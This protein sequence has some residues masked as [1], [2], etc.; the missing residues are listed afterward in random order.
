MTPDVQIRRLAESQCGNITREQLRDCGFS[1]RQI[2]IRR[3]SGDLICVLPGI[4]RLGGVPESLDSLLVATSQ[5]MAYEGFFN[6]TTA[7]YLL[8]L[9]GIPKPDRISV[10]RQAGYEAPGWLK[11]CRLETSDNPSTR[12]VQGF[13][14]SSPERAL[15]EC[16][17]L[18]PTRQVGRALDDALRRRLTTLDRMW[19]FLETSWKGRRGARVLRELLRMRD[20]RDEKVRSCFETKMLAILRRIRK[21]RF[22]PD[23]G[24]EVDG[25]RYFVDFYLPAAGLGIECHSFRWHMGRHNSD[26]RRDRAI[27]SL[28]IE[29]IYFTWD[30]VVF[31]AREVEREIRGAIARRMRH[32]L[33]NR[34][35][36]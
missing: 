35:N 11:V 33:E 31:H 17:S 21:H 32:P 2:R 25:E 29:I 9:D 28:D 12:W 14:I 7:A 13:R 3:A 18:L 15:A 26:V 1:D 36:A 19:S 5:W 30:D 20:D 10:A 24:V 22:V 23:F 27:R 8:R 4:F 16:I 6:G 34:L